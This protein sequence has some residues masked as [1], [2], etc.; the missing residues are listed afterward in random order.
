MDRKEARAIVKNKAAYR[1]SAR[2]LLN[3]MVNASF[4]DKGSHAITVKAGALLRCGDVQEAQLRN[5]LKLFTDDG[6]A[7]FTRHNGKIT[8]HVNLEPMRTW[9]DYIPYAKREETKADRATKARAVYAQ[10]MEASR[11]AEDAALVHTAQVIAVDRI[12]SEA[13]LVIA[14]AVAAL[15]DAPFSQMNVFEEGGA[16]QTWWIPA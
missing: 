15:K 4:N 12:K 3:Y 2:L 9:P 5:I 11:Q 14:A 8:M 10:K 16:P 6:I 1:G 7:A 13:A